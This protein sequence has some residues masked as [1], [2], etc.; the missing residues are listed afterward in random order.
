MRKRD[1]LTDPKSCMSKAR[2][3]EFTFVLLARD[4]AAPETIRFW[5]AERIRLGKNKITDPQIVE[6][7]ACADTMS[8]ER[9]NSPAS[10]ASA[11]AAP[12]AP[13]PGGG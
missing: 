1:E 4:E 13:A 5:C 2:E 12:S 7:L 3:D 11:T 8:I 9:V 10:S 6:A